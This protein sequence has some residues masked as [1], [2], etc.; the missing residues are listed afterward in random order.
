MGIVLPMSLR[1]A[2][3]VS[4]P[5]L[6]FGSLSFSSFWSGQL[7]V[8]ASLPPSFLTVRVDVRF[9][10]PISYSHFHVPTGSA[11]FL[12]SAAPA[13]PQSPS[14]SATERIAFMNR[15]RE[16]VQGKRSNVDRRP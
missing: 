3:N 7:I 8:P 12:S 2:E 13:R 1:S 4:F 6:N 14:T 10:P 5:S 11:P 15:L 16:V 9:A